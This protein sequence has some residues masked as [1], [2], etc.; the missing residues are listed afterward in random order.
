[1]FGQYCYYFGRNLFFGGGLFMMIFWIL[2]LV[3]G[4]IFLYKMIKTNLKN[5]N[6]ETLETLKKR[7]VSGEISKEEFERIK[8]DIA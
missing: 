4:G 5:E 7:Y 8:K 6:N 1:M 2:L 3:L